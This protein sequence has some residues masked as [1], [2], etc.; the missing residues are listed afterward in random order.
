MT[1]L[2]SSSPRDESVRGAD[3]GLLNPPFATALVLPAEKMISQIATA[4]VKHCKAVLQGYG[5]VLLIGRTT[6]L[7]S[8]TILPVKETILLIG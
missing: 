7:I 6:K 4:A 8:K 1:G 2:T 5:I 3:K